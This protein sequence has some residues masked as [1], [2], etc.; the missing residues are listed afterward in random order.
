MMLY[1]HIKFINEGTGEEQS[2]QLAVSQ[3]GEGPPSS[4]TPGKPGVLY[5]NTANGNL[6]KCTA[7]DP[8]NNSY[9]WVAMVGAGGLFAA[10]T[11]GEGAEEISVMTLRISKPNAGYVLSI[12][13]KLITEDNYLY[14][15]TALPEDAFA[16]YTAKLIR[17]LSNSSSPNVNGG[18]VV[19]FSLV[20]GEYVADKTFNETKEA[21]NSGQTITARYDHYFYDL[22]SDGGGEGF[23]FIDRDRTG[24]SY[25]MMWLWE[26][27]SVTEQNGDVRINHPIQS[28]N[29][30]TGEVKLTA[31]DVG[32]LPDTTI[33]P[34]VP[35]KVSSFTNDSG[36][37]T[38]EQVTNAI[39]TALGVIENGTY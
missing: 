36:Y 17:N 8:A 29:G 14:E 7:A 32:A 2:Y 27:D 39:N 22:Y 9:I 20:D 26:G 10:G 23:G 28:V 1:D 16:G 19:T 15:I 30:K 21:F 33:I 38:A 4:T 37:Q 18:F 34:T 3:Y 6:Y 31:S 5:L 11:K 35:T 25:K 12:G 24:T 13:D